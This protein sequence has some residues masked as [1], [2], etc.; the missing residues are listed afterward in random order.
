MSLAAATAT[1]AGEAGAPR[2]CA[3]CRA[4]RAAD[5]VVELPWSTVARCFCCG[6]E[7]GEQ[8]RAGDAVKV[9]RRRYPR[10]EYGPRPVQAFAGR[11][12]SVQREAEDSWCVRVD[13]TRHGVVIAWTCSVLPMS[14]AREG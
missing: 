13:T 10:G 5:D 4:W 3:E 6:A 9:Q 7:L 12:V 2:W 11:V 14:A 8:L 1:G